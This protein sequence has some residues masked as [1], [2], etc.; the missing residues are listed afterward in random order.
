[1]STT[2]VSARNSFVVALSNGHIEVFPAWVMSLTNSLNSMKL[3]V[4]KLE[5]ILGTF[6]LPP[7]S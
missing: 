7:H 6:Q 5:S 1:M 3:V 4:Q 2:H